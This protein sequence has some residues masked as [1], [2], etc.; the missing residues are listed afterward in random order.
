MAARAI[1]VLVTSA[2][3][4]VFDGTARDLIFPGEQGTFEV[5]PLH[6][7]LVSRLRPGVILIDGRAVPIR[8]GVVRIA[9]DEVTAVVELREQT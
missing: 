9:D 4:A 7:P 2:E 8:R 6:R 5:L 1:Q 3:R